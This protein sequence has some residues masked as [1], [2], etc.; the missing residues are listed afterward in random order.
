MSHKRFWID[1]ERF[2]LSTCDHLDF[3][4]LRPQRNPI[5]SLVG[6]NIISSH[7]NGDNEGW[8]QSNVT[9]IQGPQHLTDGA[10]EH[11]SSQIKHI[12]DNLHHT[13]YA[14]LYNHT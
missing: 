9:E 4:G 6:I 10:R 12:N 14:I 3:G 5:S 1:Y 7:C 2:T 13:L 8:C 11:I